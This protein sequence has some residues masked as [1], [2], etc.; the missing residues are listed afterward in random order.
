MA[1]RSVVAIPCRKPAAGLQA[2]SSKRD[3]TR[4]NLVLA[5]AT[6]TDFIYAVISTRIFCLPNCPS[7]RPRRANVRYFD[8]P[9]QAREA[10]F[11]PCQRCKPESADASGRS[12]H[13]VAGQEAV[14]AACAFVRDRSGEVQMLQVATHVG[15]SPRYFHGLF[16]QVMGVTPGAYA[17]SVRETAS[18][19]GGASTNPDNSAPTEPSS[20]D[21]ST[22]ELFELMCP[23]RDQH[24]SS[25]AMVTVS[26]TDWTP[27]SSLPD[28]GV[29]NTD[30]VTFNDTN[31]LPP[32]GIFGLGGL[33]PF[34]LTEGWPDTMIY[35]ESQCVDPS[36]LES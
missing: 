9:A 17:T 18:M 1:S 36:L 14:A 32:D 6:Q 30:Q 3:D 13:A 4:W 20:L 16:K 29:L 35:A 2:P 11:R 8:T 28:F 26:S 12:S 15:L 5:H 34:D 19:Q 7:R 33:G 31:A 23:S 22:N 21:F 27:D 10:G 24:D 25:S